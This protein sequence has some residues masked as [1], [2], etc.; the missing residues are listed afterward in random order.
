MKFWHAVS[1]VEWRIFLQDLNSRLS[2]LCSNHA[3]SRAFH[4]PACWTMAIVILAVVVWLIVSSPLIQR[5]IKLL[6]MVFS[7][8]A[9]HE[10]LCVPNHLL[11]V[12]MQKIPACITIWTMPLKLSL[13]LSSNYYGK[14]VT[15]VFVHSTEMRDSSTNSSKAFPL[16]HLSGENTCDVLDRFHSSLKD[17]SVP[18]IGYTPR[19]PA[20]SKYITLCVHCIKFPPY[21]IHLQ[22]ISLTLQSDSVCIIRIFLL[23]HFHF[24]YDTLLDG[25]LSC[26]ESNYFNKCSTARIVCY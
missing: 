22:Q 4:R 26:S 21:Y 7:C 14:V 23:L 18:H 9:L 17:L 25:K 16:L 5:S 13:I 1:S 19:E 6:H 24:L 3:Q 20:Q 10:Q 11:Q 2:L 15:N 8:L 12:F